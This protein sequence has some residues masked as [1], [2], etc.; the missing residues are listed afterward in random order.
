M[1][2]QRKATSIE[3]EDQ[4]DEIETDEADTAED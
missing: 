2:R 1:L 3:D 4:F